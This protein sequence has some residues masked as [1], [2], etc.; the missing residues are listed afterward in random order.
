[1]EIDLKPLIKL[2]K[3]KDVK[4]AKEWLEA[5]RS[6][7]NSG[8]EFTKG[9]LLA[10]QGMVSAMESGGELST[11]NKVLEKNYG[12]QIAEILNEAKTRTAQKFRPADE[13]G[14]DT[15]WI[16]VLNELCAKNSES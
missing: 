2:M 10:L 6:K 9:Y 11:I 7:T 15:A 16:D 3:K 12:E 4:G 13:R 8:D 1:M 5:T 14:F